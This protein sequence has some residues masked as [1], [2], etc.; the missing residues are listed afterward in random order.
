MTSNLPPLAQAFSGALGSAVANAIS[1]PLDLVG[2][3]LQT[4]RRQKRTDANT[5]TNAPAAAMR[6]IRRIVRSRGLEGLYSGLQTDTGATLLS[7]CV[8]IL[9]S[10]AYFAEP[11]GLCSFLYFYIYSFLRST[12]LRRASA[13]SSKKSASAAVLEELAIGYAAG[14]ASRAISTPLSLVTVRLQT[15]KAQNDD[16]DDDDGAE[17]ATV[18]TVVQHIYE[19]DGLAG[20]WRGMRL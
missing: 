7:K 18:K 16:A 6:E 17:D 9:I 5:N 10:C 1:Y 4:E 15:E 8:S 19:E 14:V 3:R 12:A 13:S 11:L 2:A 20:F